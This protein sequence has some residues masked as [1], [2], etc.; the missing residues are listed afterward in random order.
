MSKRLFQLKSMTAYGRGTA[1]FAYGSFTVEIQSVNRRYLE[2]NINLPRLLTRFEVP[3]RK[4]VAARV[5]RGMVNV[6]IG[7]R[8]ES[9]NPVTVTPNITLAKGVKHAW[10]QIA[11][12]LGLESKIDLSLLAREKDLLLFEE[13]LPEEECFQEALEKSLDEALDRLLEMKEKEG[14]MLSKDLHERVQTLVGI[15]DEIER[16]APGG[17]ERYRQ[18]L[19]ERLEELFAGSPENEER[20]LREVALFAERIDVTEEIV[21]FRSHIAQFQG[22]LEKPLEL[23]GKTLDFL[24]QE[25]NREINTIGSKA[26][27]LAITKQVVQAKGELEKMR[28]QVQNIE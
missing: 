12:D 13:E 22:M 1:S 2:V 3:L 7:W 14:K 24:I 6:F 28:E 5:G 21:R 18:K 16:Y 11:F 17:T 19:N 26:S 9:Q 20:L 15:I 27:D 23:Q 4:K 25:L 8:S 10:E